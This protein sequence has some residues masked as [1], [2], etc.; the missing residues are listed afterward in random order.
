[1]AIV[2]IVFASTGGPTGAIP[3]YNG[4]AMSAENVTSSGTSVQS[5]AS[6]I[7]AAARITAIDAAVYVKT[8]GNPTAATGDQWYIATGATLDLFVNSGDRIAVIS[9]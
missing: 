2:N 8:G 5:S 7:G 1:M 4:G 3:A 9:A 6:P